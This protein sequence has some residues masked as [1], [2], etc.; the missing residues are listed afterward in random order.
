MSDNDHAIRR[1]TAGW[2]SC[3]A[4][5]GPAELG[6][7]QNS[8]PGEERALAAGVENALLTGLFPNARSRREFLKAVGAGTAF[9]ALE[10][11]LPLDALKAMAQDAVQPEKKTI[12][13]G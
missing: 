1:H 11:L 3:G 12:S 10:A 6:L 4:D 13:V 2:C 5:H 9:A 7:R 8:E